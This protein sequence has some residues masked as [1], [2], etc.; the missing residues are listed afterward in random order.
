VIGSKVSMTGVSRRWSKELECILLHLLE[1]VIR[2]RKAFA[3]RY[4]GNSWSHRAS[5]AMTEE[6]QRLPGLAKEHLLEQQTLLEHRYI[7]E[8]PSC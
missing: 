5:V 8:S 7:Q 3:G 2:E 6:D 1:I 4:Q